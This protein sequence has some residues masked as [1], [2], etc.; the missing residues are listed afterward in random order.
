MGEG[1]SVS[2]F[3]KPYSTVHLC[4]VSFHL[5]NRNVHVGTVMKVQC[6]RSRV[7]WAGFTTT[8]PD[9]RVK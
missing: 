5:S 4:P 9:V 6:L 2:A 1:E 8:D 7:K 3:Y